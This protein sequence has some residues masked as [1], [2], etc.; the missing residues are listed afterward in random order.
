MINITIENK[1]EIH[2]Y[3]YIKTV[4]LKRYK[5]SP[6]EFRQNSNWHDLPS[7]RKVYFQQL[8]ECLQEDNFDELS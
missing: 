4:L 7:E 1:D 2:D 8:I 6:E 3:D 5:L